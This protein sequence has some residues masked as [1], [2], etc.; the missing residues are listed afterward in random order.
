MDWLALARPEVAKSPP[1]LASRPPTLAGRRFRRSEA[2]EK[3]AA[4]LPRLSDGS[5]DALCL[6]PP[7]R[8]S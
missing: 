2:V 6:V 7:R 4:E 8:G 5:P 1:T 3:R